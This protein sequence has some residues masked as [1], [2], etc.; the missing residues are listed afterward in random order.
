MSQGTYPADLRVHPIKEKSIHLK[1]LI[2]N[3]NFSGTLL[4]YFY[5][6]MEIELHLKVKY[7]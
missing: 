4:E 5:I 3:N 1:T 2:F 7:I 6:K